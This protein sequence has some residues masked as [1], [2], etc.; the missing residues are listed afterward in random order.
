MFS[1]G[2]HPKTPPKTA[3]LT[4]GTSGGGGR[5]GREDK[6]AFT[7][8]D[9]SFGSAGNFHLSEEKQQ[10]RQVKKNNLDKDSESNRLWKCKKKKQGITERFG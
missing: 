1:L 6:A 7:K 10:W 9:S 4:E 5:G 2:M 8:P 3:E